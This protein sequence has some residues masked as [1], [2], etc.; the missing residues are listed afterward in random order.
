MGRIR[1][2]GFVF[3]TWKRDHPP[4]HV[5]VYR[6]GELVLK[7]NLEKWKSIEGRASRG[8]LEL[9]EELER[10]GRL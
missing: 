6:D 1:P 8:I 9:I 5:H 7:W 4:R 10:E 3:T 2:G